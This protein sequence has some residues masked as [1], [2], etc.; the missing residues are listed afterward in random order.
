[1]ASKVL[2]EEFADESLKSIGWTD[3]HT[4]LNFLELTP[5][6]AIKIG[7]EKGVNRFYHY[8]H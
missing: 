6:E 2:P 7:K 8:R 4:H 1:M 3:V 5:E